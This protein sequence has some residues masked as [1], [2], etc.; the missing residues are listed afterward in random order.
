MC[1]SI[2]FHEGGRRHQEN[3]KKKLEQARKRSSENEK[4]KQNIAKTVSAIEHA[5]LIAYQQ[6]V[7]GGRAK[8]AKIPVVLSPEVE[9]EQQLQQLLAMDQEEVQREVE[10]KEIEEKAQQK[11]LEIQGKALET[12]YKAYSTSYVHS[13]SWQPCYT[14]EGY[15]YFYNSATGGMYVLL[16][17]LYDWEVHVFTVCH[18][19]ATHLATH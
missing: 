2:E 8:K 1:Q 9:R 7:A 6:D 13:V 19:L 4:E 3:A 5:A 10:K 11:I 17:E 12:A 18:S 15:T 16:M 14:P